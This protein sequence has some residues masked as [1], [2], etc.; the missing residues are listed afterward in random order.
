MISVQ[1]AKDIVARQTP[2]LPPVQLPL[3]KAAGL[4]LAKDVFA[5]IDIPAFEQSS[6]DGYAILFANREAALPVEG[7]MAAGAAVRLSLAQGKAMR[8]FTGAPLPEGADTVVMQENVTVSDGT[9]LIED[10]RLIQGANVRDRGAEIKAGDMAMPAG[11]PLTPAAIG[12][13]AGMGVTEVTVYPAPVICIVVTGKELQQPGQ[14]LQFGQVYE[15]NSYQLCAA[16]EQVRIKDI[17]IKQADDEP[18]QLQT[19]LQQALDSSDVVL[20]TGGVSV[21]DY[22][23]VQQAATACG[24]QQH[25][26]RVKQKPGKPLYFGTK[27]NLPVFG[28]PG[29]PSSVLS[30]FYQYVLPCLMS[31]SARQNPIQKIT[32]MLAAGYQK[33]KGLTHFLKGS[34]AGKSVT[35]LTA[36]E[37]YRLSSFAQ[38]NCLIQLEEEKEEYKEGETVTI[39]LLPV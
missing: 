2:L 37:S 3:H 32:A 34:Y 16:L 23:F 15:S 14:P 6:M 17:I 39:Y 8:I 30:C 25:F 36:Q 21:G 5:A 35:P 20:L 19:I 18:A 13:L 24:V 38:A 29:N 11:C 9:L 12:F 26:H 22:D 27:A 33:P 10:T 31:L 1:E 4:V 28:L 7:E